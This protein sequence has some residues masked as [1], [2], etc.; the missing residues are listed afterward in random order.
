[1]N[2]HEIQPCDV[3]LTRNLHESD[4]SSPGYWNHAS[5]YVGDYE[6]VE[7]QIKP[8]KVILSDLAEFW[9]RYPKIIVL[10]ANF[11]RTD[12]RLEDEYGITDPDMEERYDYSLR[13]N[14][15]IVARK[16]VGSPYRKIASLFRFLRHSERGENCVSV[17]RRSFTKTL[18]YDPGWKIPD[19]IFDD[20][21]FNKVGEKE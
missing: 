9:N 18:G 2:L 21:L 15:T 6:I 16:I 4:N 10:R 13:L 5:L 12:W 20:D 7:A 1:M 11:D 17:I 8:N 14:V 19:D 3:V